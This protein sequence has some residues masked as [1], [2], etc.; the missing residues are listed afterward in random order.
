MK[1]MGLL[2][3]LIMLLAVSPL[4]VA[5]VEVTEAE[6]EAGLPIFVLTMADGRTMRGVLYPEAAPQA[7]GNFIERANSGYYDG[8]IFHRVVPG[9]VI[10]GGDPT[11]TGSGDAGWR[12][13]GEFA[14]NGVEND[15]AHEVG[16]LSMARAQDYNSAGSQFFIVTGEARFLDGNYAAFG[17]VTEGMEVA[18]AIENVKSNTSDK[19]LEDQVIESIRVETFGETYAFEKIQ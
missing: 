18:L 17:L 1:K 14:S 9:F 2:L 13:M 8:V 7:V 16:V 15:I 6:R 10:Q 5:D 11:G 3:G 4:A 12:I 19:P